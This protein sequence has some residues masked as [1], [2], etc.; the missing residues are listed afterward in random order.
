MPPAS[1]LAVP[2]TVGLNIMAVQYCGGADIFR[3]DMTCRPK[4]QFCWLVVTMAYT[5]VHEVCRYFTDTASNLI[6][7]QAF[8]VQVHSLMSSDRLS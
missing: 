3:F 8:E 5:E 6:A 7:R 1:A 2:T 4:Q